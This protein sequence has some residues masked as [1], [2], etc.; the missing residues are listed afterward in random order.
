MDLLGMVH[1]RFNSTG[2]T[3]KPLLG[4]AEQLVPVDDTRFRREKES[5]ASIAFLTTPEGHMALLE[6]QTLKKISSF[7]AWTTIL[8]AS[9]FVLAF[10]SVPLFA[11]VWGIRWIFRRMRQAPSL[12]IRVLP[13]LSW[14][15]LVTVPLVLAISSD[16]FLLR[17]GHRTPWSIAISVSTLGFALFSLASLIS[18]IRARHQPIHRWAYFHSLFVAILFSIATLYFAWHGFIGYRSW[19]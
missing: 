16:D 11:L 12:H 6:G 2:A 8:L 14:L 17:F 4:A 19:I 10:V 1:L 15:C 5:V 9:T 3:L 7:R 18:C 13:L